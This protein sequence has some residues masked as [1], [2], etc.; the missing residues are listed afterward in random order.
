[1][2]LRIVNGKS[3]VRIGNGKLIVK[4]GNGK[5]V[6]NNGKTIVRLGKKKSVVRIGNGKLVVGNGKAIVR[7]GNGKPK[8]LQDKSF[9]YLQIWNVFG[10][11]P[12]LKF[13]GLFLMHVIDSL[14]EKYVQPF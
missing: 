8:F 7:L 6:V 2:S 3:I 1:M 4:I 13:M 10:Y 11:L 9:G 12:F 14:G 5:L